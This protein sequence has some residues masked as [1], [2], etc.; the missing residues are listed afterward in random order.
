LPIATPARRSA[1]SAAS[2]V[3][4]LDGLVAGVEAHTEVR[5]RPPRR[6][7]TARRT[8]P[9]R[10]SS[11]ATRAARARCTG[12]CCG[13]CG[14]AAPTGPRRGAPARG[15]LLGARAGRAPRACS[16][17]CACSSSPLALGQQRGER[18]RREQRVLEP[19]ALAPVRAE[20][21]VLDARAVKSP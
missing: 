5:A 16:R 20:D 1:A 17:R 15:D 4:E 12:G 14:C 6:R 13:P 7:A 19:A 11:R 8:R 21:L 2:S 9:P 10:R 3:L 18:L